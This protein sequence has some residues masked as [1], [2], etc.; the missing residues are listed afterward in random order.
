MKK[1]IVFCIVFFIFYSIF[2]GIQSEGKSFPGDKLNSKQELA[3]QVKPKA[4]SLQL[5]KDYGKTPL[6]FIHNEGQ[7]D[8]KA[9]YYVKA[10]NYT[11]WMITNGLVFDKTRLI[12]KTG[13]ETE[14]TPADFKHSK[15]DK[16]ERNVSRLIFLGSNG[17]VKIASEEPTEYKVNYFRGND[18]SKWYSDIDT[19]K[20]VKY[21]SIYNGIDLR[22]YGIEKQIE[23]DWIV[24]PGADPAYIRFKYENVKSIEIDSEGDLVID[25]D[26]GS[27]IHKKPVSYQIINGE[28]VS[29]KADFKK[30]GD[31]SYGFTVP[32]YNTEYAVVIDPLILEYSTYLG[33]N[34]EDS[35][36]G[37]A[38]DSEGAAYITGNTSSSDFPTLNQYQ[39][40]QGGTDVFITKLSSTGNS[41]IYST[42]LGGSA[43]DY[44]Y[45]IAV[46]SEDAAYV[47]GSTSSSD[48]PTLNQYQ[49]FQG[50]TDV[51]VTKLS[52]TGNSLIYS[53]CL[54][55]GSWDEGHGIAVDSRGAAYITGNTNSTDFPTVN[56]YQTDQGNYDIFITKF[57]WEDPNSAP[58]A[59]IDA[60]SFGGVASVT[61][62]FNGSS[63][64][65]SDGLVVAWRW[66]FGD[67]ASGTGETIAHEYTSTGT[68]TV[69]LQ[70]RD[71]DGVWS[72][73]VSEQIQV[74]NENEISCS[75][76]VSPLSI[77]ANSR[78]IAVASVIYYYTPS[79]GS[80]TVPVQYDLKPAF[81][82]TD[83]S[84]SGIN[85]FNPASGVYT[86]MLT[87][88]NPGT[89]T[90]TSSLAGDDICS[91]QITYTWPK[92]PLN[93]TAEVDENRGLFKGKL[94]VT[95]SWSENTSDLYETAG[96]RV[97]RSVNGSDWELIAELSAETYTY[98]DEKLSVKDQYSYAVTKIDTDGDESDKAVINIE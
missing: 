56:Q 65:D 76:S 57:Q 19:S 90:I 95:L 51:F 1:S 70:V 43:D 59:V 67:G 3:N 85:Q 48:F 63:S 62:T 24:H 46:D 44:G 34:D 58:V 42:Y 74:Y 82:A 29:I 87:S 33:G 55:G 68:Y 75:L 16:F 31:N 12:K 18:Q 45:G 49:A 94:F 98:T 79:D 23:Y 35:G 78:E 22:V 21:E 81:T 13:E 66:S 64:Y 39:A 97:Y 61:I 37:I 5:E 25:T 92:S 50:G 73:Y 54:G 40:Y 6:Y 93:L 4:A 30:L 38:V 26:F 27:L 96:Y 47:T 28:K 69:S 60:D 17:E 15:P 41:L 83:G 7:V 53:T 91:V 8:S 89:A 14:K 52:S 2:N 11:L 71:N 20:S 77:K 36:N 9:Q 88:G 72:P 32:E 86:D 84:F 10:H 80:G